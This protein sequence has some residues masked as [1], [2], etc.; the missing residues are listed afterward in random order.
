M[1]AASW[2]VGELARRTGLSVRTLHHYDEIGLLS[3]R[4]RTDAGYRLYTASDVARLQQ[5]KSLR[6]LGFSLE[7]I[8]TFLDRPD[9]SPRHVI[10][11]H[12]QRIKEQMELQSELCRRLEAIAAQLSRAEEVS[13][14]EFFHTME[15]M[16]MMDRINSYYT[17]EQL[18]TLAQRRQQLG[19]EEIKRVEAEWPELI[20]RVRA[21]M[22]RGTDPSDERVLALA[23]R[24]LALVES[25]T[26]G[27]PAIAKSLQTM[28]QNEPVVLPQFGVDSD[29]GP[30]VSKAM[31]AVK[32][33]GSEE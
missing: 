11:L 17:P 3:P 18:E 10:A 8:R 5:I 26:G 32:A 30:Y 20:T 21:E 13:A 15:V 25:F 31:V 22:E 23:R 19:E 12:I 29:L 4:Q 9:A 24:W 27:D 14:D 7:E 6:E 2:R 16:S 33:A 28:Y 1:T